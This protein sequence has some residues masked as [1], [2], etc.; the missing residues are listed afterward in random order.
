MGYR[1]RRA[2]IPLPGRGGSASHFAAHLDHQPAIEAEEAARPPGDAAKRLTQNYF[3]PPQLTA[4]LSEGG[5]ANCAT[6]VMFVR[7][8]CGRMSR[9]LSRL[10]AVHV[11][12]WLV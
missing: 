7:V 11:G 8:A 4:T 5:K 10:F 3:P 9:K 1:P 2:T 12:G 6:S